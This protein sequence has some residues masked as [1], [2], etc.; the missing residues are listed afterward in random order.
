[1]IQIRRIIRGMI[2]VGWR[3]VAWIFIFFYVFSQILYSPFAIFQK[4]NI[5]IS[6]SLSF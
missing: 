2:R 3:H 4:P 6:S 1:M 5:V